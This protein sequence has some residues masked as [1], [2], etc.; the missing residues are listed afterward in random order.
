MRTFLLSALSAL[1]FFPMHAQVLR[2]QLIENLGTGAGSLITLPSGDHLVCGIFNSPLTLGDTTL[3]PQGFDNDV[4]L[5]LMTPTASWTWAAS[6]SSAGYDAGIIDLTP[7]GKLVL[8]VHTSS[9]NALYGNSSLDNLESGVHFLQINPASGEL[10]NFNFLASSP[11]VFM[12]GIWI[13]DSTAICRA[14]L[15][16]GEFIGPIVNTG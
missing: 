16:P 8:T 6:V 14:A 13:D 12:D 9:P 7:D 1:I 15:L 3:Y 11:W 5:G 10:L 4:F 2:P